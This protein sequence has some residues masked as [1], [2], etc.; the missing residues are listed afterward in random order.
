[1]RYIVA[2]LLVLT[3]PAWAKEQGNLPVVT[4]S[5]REINE[6]VCPTVADVRGIHHGCLVYTTSAN[7]VPQSARTFEP[8][9]IVN[10]VCTGSMNADKVYLDCMVTPMP[11]AKK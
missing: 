5:P 11:T 3:A 4:L 8:S 1:M 9:Q 6:A 10:A 7:V 2:L